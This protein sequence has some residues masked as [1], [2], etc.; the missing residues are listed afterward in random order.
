MV[1]LH[2][3]RTVTFERR[4]NVPKQISPEFL[5]VDHVNEL[6]ELVEDR[7]LSFLAFAN[8][9]KEWTREGFPERFLCTEAFDAEEVS[10]DVARCRLNS[11]CTKEAISG[12]LLRPLRPTKKSRTR[13]LGKD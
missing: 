7:M 8:E 6:G 10:A 2:S 11:F 4:L 13:L 3:V 12:R 5:L 1:H 9:P